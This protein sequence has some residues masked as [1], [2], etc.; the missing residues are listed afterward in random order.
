MPTI[1]NNIELRSDEVQEILGHIPN[2]II[3]YG[4]V[5]ILS[6]IVLVFAG[7]F[8][9]KYPDIIVADVEI[10]T[11]NPPAEI[12]AKS[13]G[14]L[15]DIFVADSQFVIINQKL[16]V[17][18]NS[19]NNKHIILLRSKLSKINKELYNPKLFTFLPDT[20]QLGDLQG[21]YSAFYKASQQYFQFIEMRYFE[22]K[23]I[24]LHQK[25]KQ[26]KAYVIILQ[27]QAVL[28]NEECNLTKKQYYRDSTLHAKQVISTSDLEKSKKQTIQEDIAL[29][30]SKSSVINT[31]LQ[32]NELQQ[33][34]VEYELEQSKQLNQHKQVLKELFNNLESRIAWWFDQYVLISPINGTVAFN[35]IW[36]NN[37]HITSGSQVFSIIPN[38]KKTIIGRVTLNSKGAGKVKTGQT[39]NIK[40]SNYPYQEF[41][42][43]QAQVQSISLLPIDDVYILELNLPDTLVTN[44]G[45]VLPFSQKM[46]GTAEIITED[47]PLIVR[48]FNPLKAILKK[49]FETSNNNV[50]YLEKRVTEKQKPQIHNSTL[51]AAELPKNLL[52][53]NNIKD[54]TLTQKKSAQQYYVIAGSFINKRAIQKAKLRF[55]KRG[56]SCKILNSN[57][58]RYRLSIFASTTKN[59]ALTELKRIKKHDKINGVWILKE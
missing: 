8:F 43:V 59:K 12:I 46:S 24:S 53:V 45:M 38:T 54:D 2:R 32:I 15:S 17:I 37:Q 22:T 11:Q 39:V 52:P 23:L 56:Y 3:R 40:I 51:Q 30:S 42:M 27:E 36:S 48:L 21:A 18:K 29:R 6:I 49:H 10:V 50:V 58:S 13:S 1:N 57:N 14:N 20:M 9:F 31:K 28:K 19:A 16:G 55:E 4:I 41:G 33:Q 44:Y 25:Q 35:K 5:V 34:I 7:S 47:L 26:L